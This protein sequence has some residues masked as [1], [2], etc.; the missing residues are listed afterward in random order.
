MGTSPVISGRNGEV[1]YF[2]RTVALLDSWTFHGAE[3]DPGIGTTVARIVFSSSNINRFWVNFAAPTHIAL[4]QRQAGSKGPRR[5]FEL[6]TCDL[7]SGKAVVRT[8][9]CAI[10]ER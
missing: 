8:P 5:V 6:I 9:A 10:E 4:P 1:R 3:H 7:A 2:D